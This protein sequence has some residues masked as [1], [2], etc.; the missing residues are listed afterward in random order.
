M[1]K[2]IDFMKQIPSV[3]PKTISKCL[4]DFLANTELFS[5]TATPQNTDV[6]CHGFLWDMFLIL[7]CRS[8][9]YR[10]L[11]AWESSRRQV[12]PQPYSKFHEFGD[13]A[14]YSALNQQFPGADALGLPRSLMSHSSD[15]SVG[16]LEIMA[17]DYIHSGPYR[18]RLTNQL[19]EHLTLDNNRHIRLYWDDPSLSRRIL[20]PVGPDPGKNVLRTKSAIPGDS[21]RLYTGHVLGKCE[22]LLKALTLRALNADN[23]AQE[24]SDSYSMLFSRNAESQSIGRKLFKEKDIEA[25]FVRS[26]ELVRNNHSTT[27]TPVP[28]DENEIRILEWYDD[29][30][31]EGPMLSHFE[32]YRPHL[33]LL[34]KQMSKWKP[35]RRRDLL[36]PGY[37]DKFTYYSTMFGIGIG[38]LGLAGVLSTIIGTVFTGLIL[39]NTPTS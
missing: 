11:E 1:V 27:K 14:Q 23:I 26:F 35:Q 4:H 31:G 9:S 8:R 38:L 18:L 16:S 29:V 21:F 19:R 37:T 20:R 2:L 25:Q 7:V 32:Y 10:E 24:I 3:Q 5:I 15:E 12:I 39:R 28:A 34:A 36:Q 17:A 33:A 13:K 6:A 30:R 22:T